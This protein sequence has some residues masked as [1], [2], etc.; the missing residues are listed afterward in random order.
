MVFTGDNHAWLVDENGN[1]VHE[2][3]T[4]TTRATEY[5][6]PESMPA[7]LPPTS[8]Y[9]YCAELSVDGAQRVRFEKPVTV[10]V[11]NFLGFDVGWLFLW[12]ITIVIEDV[13][14]PEKNGKV[15]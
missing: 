2:L 10:C 9:T 5:T 6:T 12:D 8:A 14:V 1:D 3:P 13:W 11:D 4:I 15:D 7:V